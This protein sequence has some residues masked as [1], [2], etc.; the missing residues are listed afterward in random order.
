MNQSATRFLVLL[1][2]G[3][4]LASTQAGEVVIYTG[5]AGWIAKA[6]ADAQA[7]ICVN[8]LN[9]WGIPNTWYWDAT[10]AA[11]DKAAIAT[12]MTAKTGNGEPDVLILYGVFPETIYP[13]PNVQPDGSIA[14]LFIESTDGDMIIN[15]GDAMFFVTGAGSN[16][17]YTGLQSMM[18]NT[19]ITQAADNTPMK[20]TAAGKAIA[21]SLN[22]FWS[23]RMWFPAQLR[24]EWFV[25]AALARNHDGTRVEATIMRDGPRGRLMMLFQTNGEGWNPKGAVAAE[26]C[27]WVFGVNRGAPTAVGVRAVKAAKAAILAFPPATGVTDTTPVAWAGDAVEVTVDLL[28][29]TGSS[30]LSATDVTVNLTT[31]SATGR[32]DT[33]ADGSF[34]AS[35]ISVTI[36]A[37]SPYVDVYYKDAVTCTPTLTASSASLASGSRLMKI[38]A[39]TYA[40]GGEVAF[41]TA[42]VSWVGAATAN[43]QAQIAANKLSILGV[44]SGI[45][46]AID[47][48]V[49]LDEADLAAWMTAKTGNGRLDV[50]MIFGFVPPTIYAYNNTQ[51]DGSIAELFIESTDGDVIISSGDAF[52]YVTRTT[53]NGYN[54]LRYL[55]DMRDFLQ[56]AGTITSVVTPLGQM[57]TPSLNNFTSDRPFCI[58]M[59]LNNWLVEAAAAGG[60]SGGRAAADPVCIR[61]GDRG[62]IIPLL[63]RSDDNL[64]RGAVAADIIASLYGYMPAVPTQFALVGRTVGGVE[65]PLK[66]AAQVQGLTGSPAKATADTTVTLT[67]DS[68][69]GKFDVALDGAYDGSV[70]SVLIPAGSSSAVFYYKD[71]AAGMRAL[72]ASATGFTAATINVNVFPRTFSPAGEVAVYTGKT[73][74]IDKG[75]ADGQADVLAARLAPSG[76]PV[77]LYKAEADQAALAA[78]VTAKTNDGKQD[79]LILYGCFPRSIYPTSTALT[80]GTLAEL[81]IES[82]DGD[83]IV[84]SGDWMFYCDYDAADMRYENGAAALQSMMDTPGIGMGADNTLVSLTA[85]GRAIAPSLRTFLTDRPFFPDQFANEWYVEA[86][87][88]R[89]ADGTR[90]E[91]AMIR[92]GNRGR[93]VALFQTN[94]MDVNTAPEPKGAVGA[95][96]VAWLMGVDLAPTKLGLANDGGAAVAFARDPAKLTVKLLDAAG[97]PTPAAADVTANLASSASGAFDIAKDGN[98]DGSVT[99]VTIPAGAASAIVYFRA[100]TTGAVTVSATDAGAVLGG[101]D[102]ALTVYES[103]VLEQGSVAIYTGTVGWTDKPSADAQAEICVDKLNAVGIANTWYRNAT[104]VDAI[105]AWVASV[106]ND[107]KTDV[108]VLYGSL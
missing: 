73:W 70:T 34:S 3:A 42:G 13:P 46:S 31:D 108:L 9:A 58:D 63:Q 14:E 98:F 41:Y 93:L 54:G 7:Q 28:E 6:D 50:L 5:Q 11:A 25:E 61:D 88:A 84:N 81:F 60:I 83:A 39:R 103:P 85:D 107:G 30:T 40:P 95:E 75:L 80:D 45:Y 22:E 105:A 67:A 99:S 32:F 27:S 53:N 36:P 56:S 72:T 82:A 91:P 77:T 12:W 47:D 101:A 33:A 21:S 68:A 52:W 97:V 92:D 20:I 104:D 48:P 17:T 16:N 78:W 76:I 79:V 26:V 38:F 89:N 100:R 4:M 19:L 62:R 18:D 86:A 96:M 87:L 90:V 51:P 102:L 29:A 2:L 35:S 8:K 74:W 10:T 59:L 15:H 66:F 23:D 65:E 55:T 94:A 44:T 37:G 106:T 24:G 64:P 43:A 1:L 49:L 71:T 57:L 69:T